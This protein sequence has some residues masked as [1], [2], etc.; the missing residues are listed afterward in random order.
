MHSLRKLLTPILL[1][2][3]VGCSSS[4]LAPTPPCDGDICVVRGSVEWFNL[5]GG[6]FAIR[7]DDQVTYDPLNLPDTFREDGLRVRASVRIRRDYGSYH[8]VG[9]MVDVLSIRRE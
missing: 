3:A 7:G 4:S 6:F 2:A 8:M 9:P 5:E 1:A